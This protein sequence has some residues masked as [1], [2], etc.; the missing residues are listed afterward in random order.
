[1]GIA[2][3]GYADRA[4][5]C[6]RH[7]LFL[8]SSSCVVLIDEFVS[9][10][11]IVSTPAVEPALIRTLRGGRGGAHIPLAARRQSGAG[12]VPLPRQRHL[13]P[14]RRLG[15]AA[16]PRDHEPEWKMQYNLRFTCNLKQPEFLGVRNRLNTRQPLRRNLAT[17]LAPSCRDFRGR[18]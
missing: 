3:A 11:S 2:D 9:R 13:Q 7:V 17:V 10:E 18:R 16:Q 6:R 1:M 4:E 8:K 14:H 12:G 15:S 5:R